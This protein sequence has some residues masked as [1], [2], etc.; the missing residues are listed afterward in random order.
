MET[1]GF[2]SIAPDHGSEQENHSLKV[3]VGIVGITQNKKALD[4]F[5]LI[6]P[7][8][9]KCLQEFAIESST[10]KSQEEN[11]WWLAWKMKIDTV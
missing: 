4:K 10:M 9:S 7:K 3:I 1:S 2:I 8:L 5:F 6:A 11:C